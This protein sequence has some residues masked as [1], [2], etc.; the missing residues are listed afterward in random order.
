VTG[1]AAALSDGAP[2]T[3]AAAPPKLDLRARILSTLERANLPLLASALAFD[4]LLAV[5]PLIGLILAGLSFFFSRTSF[6]DVSPG[7]IVA[8]FL[9]Q[10]DFHGGTTDPFL[11]VEHLVNKIQGYNA[12]KLTLVAVPL[13]LWFSTRVFAAVRICLSTVFQVRQRPVRGHFVWSYIAGYLLGKARDMAIVIVVVLLAALNTISTTL[14]SVM[15]ARGVQLD[16][17]WSWLVS[18]G[19]RLAGQGLAFLFGIALFVTLYRYASPK[20]L[21][22]S[23]ALIAATLATVGFELAKRVY[24]LYLAYVSHAGQ[25]SVDADLGAALLF[26]LWIW[27]MSLVFLFGA[28]TADVWDHAREARAVEGARLT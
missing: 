13:A 24:G 6:A 10:H 11:V 25:F 3:A 19:G 14:L 22:W 12:T 28:A 8:R 21:A 20:R 16:P 5:I 23:G 1:P 9:P 15:T 2:A 7:D 27:Y 17:H 26:I 18:V 4:A